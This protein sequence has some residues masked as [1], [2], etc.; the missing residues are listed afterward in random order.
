MVGRLAEAAVV[1]LG[2]YRITSDELMEF[3]GVTALLGLPQTLLKSA[4]HAG[5]RYGSTA[6]A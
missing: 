2:L 4:E 3:T 6:V 1:L 5:D